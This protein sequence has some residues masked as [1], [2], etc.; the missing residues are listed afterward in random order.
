MGDPLAIEEQGK[1]PDRKVPA[2]ETLATSGQ[3]LLEGLLCAQLAAGAITVT[4]GDE[5][6][7]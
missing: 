1:C 5:S 4:Q 3:P 6:R 7:L 2:C